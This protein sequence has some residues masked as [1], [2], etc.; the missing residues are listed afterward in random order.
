MSEGRQTDPRAELTIDV[1]A[2]PAAG[3][4]VVTAVGGLEYEA[5]GAFVDAVHDAFDGG[6]AVVVAD[7]SGVDYCDS[8]GLAALVRCNKTAQRSGRRFVVRNPDP[9]LSRMLVITCLDS[10]L[11]VSGL[12]SGD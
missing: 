10:V 4:V 5:V 12:R 11:E 3:E 9:I 7:V 2:G 1:T 8:S 6:A